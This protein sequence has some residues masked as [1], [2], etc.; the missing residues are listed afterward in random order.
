MAVITRT[1]IQTSTVKAV[2]CDLDGT[3][4]TSSG[5]ADP[6][7]IAA[8]KQLKAQNILFGLCTGRG[9]PNIMA[10]LSAWG[11]SNLP[12]AFVASGGVDIVDCTLGNHER[13]SLLARDTIETIIDH[14]ASCSA[15]PTVMVDG[16]LCA[17][18]TTSA[19][20]WF[21]ERESIPYRKV[22]HSL[23]TA[24]D[25]PKLTFIFEPHH[26]SEVAEAANNLP[27]SLPAVGHPT[28]PYLF[29]FTNPAVSKETALSV[30]M[31]WHGWSMDALL[32]FGDEQNDLGMI[33]AAGTGVAM[34]NGCAEVLAAADAITTGND[35]N[36][37]GI[38][39]ENYL[40]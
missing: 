27:H 7:T 14:L 23:L 17:P 25:Y 34:A 31:E 33:R 3:L 38:F 10:H 8:I 15:T 39:I 36:G 29:E 2:M 30:L 1:N 28:A 18:A 20:R 19:V 16:V 9:L 35:E 13:R 6:R 11:L 24:E 12:D 21:S 26:M 40:L 5:I 4:L 32:V 22:P 37:I